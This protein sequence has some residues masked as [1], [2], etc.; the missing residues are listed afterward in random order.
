MFKVVRR[1]ISKDRPVSIWQFSDIMKT[2]IHS[3]PL[4]GQLGFAIRIAG[5]EGIEPAM[6]PWTGYLLACQAKRSK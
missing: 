3:F 1:T 5:N 4:R 2:P 6:V